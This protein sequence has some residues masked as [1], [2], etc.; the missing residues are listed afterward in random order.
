MIGETPYT[1]D[2]IKHGMIRG[3]QPKPGNF[4]GIL[5]NNDEK[6]QI[7]PNVS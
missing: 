6:T 1:L 5:K 7:L 3:N 2:E 4:M